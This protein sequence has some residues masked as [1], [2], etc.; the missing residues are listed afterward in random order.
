MAHLDR[1][2]VDVA[3]GRT[4]HH[5]EFAHGYTEVASLSDGELTTLDD[6]FRARVLSW[7]LAVL[8]GRADAATNCELRQC[9]RLLE[10]T[11]PFTA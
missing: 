9:V 4:T 5:D 3:C 8:E 6:L 11:R 7:G 10:R 1:R 2:A